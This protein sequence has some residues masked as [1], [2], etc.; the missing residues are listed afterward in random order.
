MHGA[1]SDKQT[2]RWSKL[3]RRAPGP[4]PCV[5]PQL[6]LCQRAQ[7]DL[8]GAVGYPQGPRVSPHPSEYK[9]LSQVTINKGGGAILELAAPH[10]AWFGPFP[11]R[12]RGRDAPPTWLTPAPPWTWTAASRTPEAALGANTLAAAMAPM[13]PLNPSLRDPSYE[14][15]VHC[16]SSWYSYECPVQ[17]LAVCCQKPAPSN[18]YTAMTSN[19]PRPLTHLSNADAAARTRSRAES[20]SILDWASLA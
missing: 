8:V 2:G 11:L 6:Q 4:R 10:T 7:V 20:M 14:R 3:R 9:V 1:L 5:L 12:P 18:C 13:A 16:Q 15:I 17:V 19:L